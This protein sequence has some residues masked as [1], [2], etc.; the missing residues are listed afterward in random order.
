M[1][2]TS[3]ATEVCEANGLPLSKLSFCI[4]DATLCLE[5]TLRILWSL[6][7]APLSFLS[8]FLF[9]PEKLMLFSG[10]ALLGPAWRDRNDVSTKVYRVWT[11][12]L[13]K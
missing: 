1:S 9:R 10:S 3:E 13:E 11:G 2:E 8:F 4:G 6:V 7:L 5:R 12:H